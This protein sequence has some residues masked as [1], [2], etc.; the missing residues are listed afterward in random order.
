MRIA[1]LTNNYKP[2]IGGVPISIERLAEGLRKIGHEVYIFAPKYE[3]CE[4]VEEDIIRYRIFKG[5]KD[6]FVIP[7]IF[8]RDIETEFRKLKIDVIHVHHPML[9]GWIGLYLGNKYEVPVVLTYHTKYEEYLH[10]I[11]LYNFIQKRHE[12]ENIKILKSLEKKTMDFTYSKLVP[13]VI[14]KF[15]NRCNL[16]FAPTKMIKEN[17]K[18]HGVRRHIDI[19][20]TGLNESYF[21]ENKEESKKIRDKH[22]NGKQ[23]LFCTVSR[24]TK[25]KNIEFIINGLKELKGRIG[26]DF[27]LLV[28]GQGNL[29]ESLIQKCV[30]LG[31]SDNVEFLNSISN[32]IIGNYYRACDMFLFASKSETQGIVLLEA[33]AAKNPVVAIDATGVC[34]VVINGENGYMTKEDVN[35]WVDKVVCLLTNKEH[36]D[37]I[38]EGAYKTSLA[39]LNST[40]ASMAEKSYEEV[41]E[42]QFKEGH[43]YEWKATH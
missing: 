18:S 28:I 33:M 3:K 35:E 12:K 34:D 21:I 7:N 42:R 43:G 36:M 25:E 13:T 14:E 29:K 31:L 37:E 23:Y 16:I 17:L 24:L 39:Y 4:E 6:S 38:R 19:L 32:D 30:S 26:D 20:P 2:F 5:N 22:L 8:D 41:L 15:C 40:I 9:M 10:H 27:K 1:M 11:G